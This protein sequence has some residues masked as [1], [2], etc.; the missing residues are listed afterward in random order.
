MAG[1]EPRSTT[2]PAASETLFDARLRRRLA[3]ELRTRLLDGLAQCPADDWVAR[4]EYLRTIELGAAPKAGAI[5]QDECAGVVT[6]IRKELAAEWLAEL[7]ASSGAKGKHLLHQVEPPALRH[8]LKRELRVL[9]DQLIVRA[10]R[11]GMVTW[12]G[13][14]ER[15]QQY[16]AGFDERVVELPLA[17]AAARLDK[18][19]KVLDAGAALNLPRLR[20]FLGRPA[21]QITHFTLASDAEPILP[22][23]D[24]VSYQ[25]GDLRATDFRDDVFD[26]IVCVS[27]L[28]HVG[29]DNSIYGGPAESRPE[30]C[31]EAIEELLRIL[32]P[33]GRLLV[34]VPYGRAGFHGWFQVFGPAELQDLLAAAGPSVTLVRYFYYDGCWFE[35][36]D[37]APALLLEGESA[38]P[39][40]GV[41][42][43][44]ITKPPMAINSGRDSRP[45]A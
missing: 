42:V 10:Y 12:R 17:L 43:A 44:L 37:E 40:V 45:S 16:G 29:M 41:A 18:P 3:K 4:L 14:L 9:R 36:D 27:T 6:A 15:A 32:A 19:G 34:T 35:G 20:Q 22:D 39:I 28:E 8:L 33:G 30:T 13:R 5:I 11:K 1:S 25:F 2:S 23:S 7:R 38:D 21:A 26:R 31:R 24:R